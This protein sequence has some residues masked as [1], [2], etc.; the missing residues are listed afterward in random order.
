MRASWVSFPVALLVAAACAVS[1][2]VGQVGCSESSTFVT[3][4][5][6]PS[7]Y[8]QALCSSLTHCCAENGVSQDYDECTK[9]WESAVS[10]LLNGPQSSGNYDV[11]AATQCIQAVRDAAGASCQPVA[12][13]LSAA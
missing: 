7:E 5:Q 9:G 3:Q 12:G 13:S 1:A 6:F 11:T 10:A 4:D 2:T 8:A